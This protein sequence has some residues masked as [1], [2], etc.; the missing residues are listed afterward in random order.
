MW[1]FIFEKQRDE[2]EQVYDYFSNKVVGKL[3]P[4]F[5]YDTYEKILRLVEND[6]DIVAFKKRELL[7]F[8]D[9]QSYAR[10]QKCQKYYYN[11]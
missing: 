10:F 2:L 9:S 5:K 6:K 1:D 8:Y 11:I 4:N 7:S 3:N